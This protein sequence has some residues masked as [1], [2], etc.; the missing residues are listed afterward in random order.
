MRIKERWKRL[1]SW[2]VARGGMAATV[3]CLAAALI[4]QLAAPAQNGL[5]ADPVAQ[6]AA[7]PAGALPENLDASVA[8]DVDAVLSVFRPGVFRSAAPLQDKPLADRT[9][10]KIR[11]QL[12]LQ[13]IMQMNGQ[14]VA[15]IH[16]KDAGLK[17]CVVG[18]AVGDLF[19]V[20]Q[21]RD[22]SVDVSILEHRVTLSL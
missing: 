22:K 16:I 19:T 13:C 5:P 21:I 12:T 3:G 6:R 2:R 4:A 14:P 1:G 9:I 7:D 18:E 8:V 17:C 11:S 15:Y 10:E 20:L